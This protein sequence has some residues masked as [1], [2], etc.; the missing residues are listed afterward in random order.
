MKRACD[1]SSGSSDEE[2]AKRGR[3]D[4][5]NQELDAMLAAN[6]VGGMDMP[7][8]GGMMGGMGMGMGAP[9]AN[10]S[11]V[12]GKGQGPPSNSA[13]G[14]GMP[15]MGGM[16]GMGLGGM[17]MKGMDMKGLGKGMGGMG[18]M[19]GDGSMEPRIQTTPMDFS[20]LTGNTPSKNVPIPKELC[21]Y[22]MT[23]EHRQILT[24]ES[25]AE[26]EWSP[27]E[28]QVQLR[29]SAEQLK[30]A[31]RL[32]ARVT[33]H[34]H[35]GRNEA[36]VKR[37]LQPRV[38][39]SVVVRLSPMNT[40]RPAEKVLSP[41]QT[42]SIGKDKANDT[43]IPD[44]IVSRQHCVLELDSERGSVYILDCSTNGTYL[45]GRR[46]PGKSAGKVL[47]SHGDELLL[48]DPSSGD[49]EYGYIV[50]L[51]ELHVKETVKLEA[52][53]R[54]LTQEELSGTFRDFA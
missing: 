16:G 38:V 3:F 46:L 39:E 40:L 12:L 8:M 25:G 14:G 23:P 9:S 10:F 1:A 6:A 27:E 13:F 7:G 54:L 53:R 34:C 17:D 43:V 26:V 20:R 33:T 4:D 22:L 32:L 41:G 31:Q 19:D 15:G 30:K 42:L 48:K 52:P 49:Q 18:G 44:A 21:Q 28:H 50:N 24:E 47:L 29:G 45:N 35:W 37:I 11:G 51:N 2:D 36:K 5:P